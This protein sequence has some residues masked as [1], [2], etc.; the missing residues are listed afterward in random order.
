MKKIKIASLL[1]ACAL[2]FSANAADV[3]L[4]VN[5]QMFLKFK[6]P[7]LSKGATSQITGVLVVPAAGARPPMLYIAGGFALVHID[8][9][10]DYSVYTYE[11]GLD[12][13]NSYAGVYLS[14]RGADK[15]TFPLGG[16]R[17]PDYNSAYLYDAVLEETVVSTDTPQLSVIK[18]K[19][20]PAY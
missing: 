18:C 15:K 4:K 19:E 1:L 17:A 8:G 10:V 12:D 11:S 16:T 2:P 13:Y 5:D 14:T 20:I 3:C 6:K 9:T 7:S